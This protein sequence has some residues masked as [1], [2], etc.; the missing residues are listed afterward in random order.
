M[1]EI[2]HK[3]NQ[4]LDALN[5]IRKEA[6]GL[7]TGGAF[8]SYTDAPVSSSSRAHPAQCLSLMSLSQQK[9]RFTNA[10]WDECTRLNT[11]SPAGQLEAAEDDI[12]P[13]VPELNMP[14]RRVKK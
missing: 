5:K 14:P 8:L 7:D 2:H 10:L 13:A 4:H 3:R 9:L 6:E 1:M 12:L 11:V